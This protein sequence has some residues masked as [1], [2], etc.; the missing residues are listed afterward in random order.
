MH[1]LRTVV[2]SVGL[3]A[4]AM[5]LTAVA[6]PVS[7]HAIDVQS[8]CQRHVANIVGT[9]GDDILS[10]TTN[11]DVIVG[12]G[13]DDVIDGKG[14]RDRVC[15]DDDQPRDNDGDDR[16]KGGVGSDRIAGGGGRD[17]LIGESGNDV[18]DGGASGD[19]MFGGHGRD[20]LS[21]RDGKD[22]LRGGRHDDRLNGGSATT[23]FCDGQAGTDGGEACE[24]PHSIALLR[25]ETVSLRRLSPGATT[26]RL[27]VVIRNTG[28]ETATGVEVEG[29]IR[30]LAMPQSAEPVLNGPSEIAPNPDGPI[31]SN[32]QYFID[33]PFIFPQGDLLRY[34]LRV[35]NGKTSID[36][37][38]DESGI[39]CT[40]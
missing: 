18:M 1:A 16:V 24:D 40:D 26:C 5:A 34:V 30:T 23:D 19:R 2:G 12:R 39:F 17:L 14:G 36:S 10:G 21:G 38:R 33:T 7:A 9:N 37:T 11:A 35:H 4:S 20:R 27:N 31:F 25:F 29:E 6:H 32:D 3:L 22:R 28:D 15:G 8:F 13:G